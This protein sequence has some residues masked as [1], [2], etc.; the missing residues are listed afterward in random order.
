MSWQYPPQ[1]GW[2]PMYGQPTPPNVI[3]VAVPTPLPEEPKGKRRRRET[4]MTE[5]SQ[6]EMINKQ[7]RDLEGLRDLFK[8]KDDKKKEE[9]KKKSSLSVVEW[10][11]LLVSLSALTTP[12]QLLVVAKM[13]G[14]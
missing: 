7:I 5:P 10:A 4:Y 6:V 8:P 14:W 1:G 11:M 13:L 2:P 3:Y 9:E 12:L